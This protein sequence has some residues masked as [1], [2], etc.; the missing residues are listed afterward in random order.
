MRA[1][2]AA[3]KAL[4]ELER[5]QETLGVLVADDPQA[6][7]LTAL[8]VEEKDARPAE[9]R[10]AREPR[11]PRVSSLRLSFRSRPNWASPA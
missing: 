6:L 11:P 7:D 3:G 1:G 10:E 5:L 2:S 9:R 8:R 4:G